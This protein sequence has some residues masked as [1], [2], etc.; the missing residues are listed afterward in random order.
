MSNHCDFRKINRFHGEIEFLSLSLF[1]FVPIHKQS[2]PKST[3]PF[4]AKT[5][6]FCDN[7]KKKDS[8]GRKN[9]IT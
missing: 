5:N 9:Q 8:A 4:D 2:V 6:I 7:S 3:Q 1:F